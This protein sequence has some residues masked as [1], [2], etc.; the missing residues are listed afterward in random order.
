M[1]Y[2]QLNKDEL[3]K[4]YD[5]CNKQYEQYKTLGLSLD[6]SRGKP[7]A[8]QLDL[9]MDLLTVLGPGDYKASDGTDCRNYGGLDGIPEM[10]KMFA[11]LMEVKPEEVLV[12]G[13]SSLTLMYESAV[14]LIK[15]KS[16]RK[17]LCPSPGYDRHFTIT[18]YLGFELVTV[19]MTPKGPDMAEVKKHVS[20]PAVAGLW[21]VPVFSNPQGVVY[22]DGIIKEMAALKPAADDFRIF[23]DNAYIVH[24]FEGDAPKILNLLKECEACGAYDR[25]V[26][27]TSFSKITFPG[28]GVAA[29]AASP[30][31]LDMMRKHLMPQTIGPDKLNQ[32]RHVRYFKDAAGIYSHM[33]KHAEALRPKFMTV[34]DILES[35]LGGKDIGTWLKPSGG[36]FISFDT[37]PGCAAR[38]IALCAEAGLVMTPAG[39]AYPYGKDPLDSNIRI[40][41]SFPPLDQLKQAMELFCTVVE[42]AALERLLKT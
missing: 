31:N 28:A 39:A 42:L 33:R 2:K 36:Y 30:A 3:Q 37:L 17:F 1:S 13:N 32:L 25:A 41:P 34:L 19:P 10:K 8:D 35:K 40:A 22:S 21:C 27:F 26:M 12:G 29:L 9:S 24:S 16:K 18:E 11:D 4:L 15:N 23:W 20:D 6:M 38:T 7:G 14:A 5:K